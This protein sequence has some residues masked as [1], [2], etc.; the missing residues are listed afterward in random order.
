L[1]NPGSRR[2]SNNGGGVAKY[3]VPQ[4]KAVG[5][6]AAG[7]AYAGQVAPPGGLQRMQSTS[8]A[9]YGAFYHKQVQ[10]APQARAQVGAVGQYQRQAYKA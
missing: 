1:S 9:S 10:N 8:H 7:I 6:S 4:H 5:P 3:G 2:A